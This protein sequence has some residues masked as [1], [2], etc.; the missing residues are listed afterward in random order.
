MI[1]LR[2]LMGESPA[3]IS[4]PVSQTTNPA[5]RPTQV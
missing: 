5:H 2:E 3:T 4:R 1:R